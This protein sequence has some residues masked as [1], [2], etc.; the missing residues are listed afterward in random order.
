MPVPF[1]A[2]RGEQNLAGA[3]PTVSVFSSP[4]LA[5]SRAGQ[6]FM[7]EMHF[8]A[9]VRG[10]LACDGH[11]SGLAL[12]RSGNRAGRDAVRRILAVHKAASSE[13]IAPAVR[14]AS[15]ACAAASS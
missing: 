12:R 3:A 9:S 2:T 15:A 6:G 5:H 13:A 7:D 10:D 8:F 14:S 1:G 4:Y 11:D